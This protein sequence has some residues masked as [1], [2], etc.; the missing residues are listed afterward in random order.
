ME[1]RAADPLFRKLDDS[2]ILETARALVKRIAERFPDSGLRQLAAE[3]VEVGQDVG[4]AS[5]W[6][7][8]PIWPIRALSILTILAIVTLAIAIVVAADR[9][10]TPYQTLS[11]LL[12][13][14]DAG[15][16]ELVLLG[17]GLWFLVSWEQ[18]FKRRRALASLHALRSLA[19][20]VDMHQLTKD[21]ERILKAGPG[22]AAA[23]IAPM[24]PVQL[25]WYLDYCSELLAMLSKLAALLVQDFD[26]PG[27][28]AAVN[29][30]E[31]LCVGLS[32][33]IWQKI[34]LV[35]ARSSGA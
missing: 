34:G 10:I 28:L 27:T 29:E 3:V 32:R 15:V 23:A 31:N 9:R 21:P 35:D 5:R 2:K 26:D 11:D 33:K 24:T 4:S 30:V 14:L 22:P 20:V 1:S 25:T 18:R 17:A 13:G 12:Q 8:R 19:H 16:N 7:A 6:L